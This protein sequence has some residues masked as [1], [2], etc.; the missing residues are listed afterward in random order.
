MNYEP[1]RA[2]VFL[3]LKSSIEYSRLREPHSNFNDEVSRLS[4]LANQCRPP[5]PKLQFK[6]MGKKLKALL[7]PAW[8]LV[9]N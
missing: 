1:F 6:E 3:H 5:N 4:I 7:N 9:T 8:L 2:K